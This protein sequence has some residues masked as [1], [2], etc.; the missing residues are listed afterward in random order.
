MRYRTV[1]TIP[2]TA[3]STEL[4]IVIP[5]KTPQ[6]TKVA[7]RYAANLADHKPDEGD[8]QR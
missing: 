4:A 5:H 8:E 1:Q 7:L 6:L 2:L 3:N